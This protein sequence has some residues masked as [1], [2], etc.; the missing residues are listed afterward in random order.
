MFH[1]PTEIQYLIYSFDPTSHLLLHQVIKQLSNYHKYIQSHY[2]NNNLG[3]YQSDSFLICYNQK[4][5]FRKDYLIVDRY[6][7][8]YYMT[9]DLYLKDKIKQFIFIEKHL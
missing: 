5:I 6:L 8:S 7:S 1:L 2:I 3:N 4:M 9:K